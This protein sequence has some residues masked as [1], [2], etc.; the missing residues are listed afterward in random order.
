MRIAAVW[1]GASDMWVLCAVRVP[2]RASGRNP[3]DKLS[4]R[5]SSA[6]NPLRPPP[7]VL[8][9][10][11]VFLRTADFAVPDSVFELVDDVHPD[12]LVPGEA[13]VMDEGVSWNGRG[14]KRVGT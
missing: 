7:P 2:R 1:F 9:H 3:Q 4:V 6:S 14:R 12:V 10:S 8:L 11:E 5:Y 13:R